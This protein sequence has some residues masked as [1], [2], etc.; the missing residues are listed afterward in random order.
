MPVI[1]VSG[2]KVKV[3]DNFLSMSPD[4]QEAT[5]NE[6]AASFGS[7]KAPE[8]APGGLGD[9]AMS[10]ITD[11]LPGSLAGGAA[12]MMGGNETLRG[13]QQGQKE[14][15]AASYQR[16]ADVAPSIAEGWRQGGLGGA[17]EAGAYGVAEN[18]GTALPGIA[19]SLLRNPVAKLAATGINSAL[20]ANDVLEER[21]KADPKA[22]LSTVD[23]GNV[24][25]QTAL[26][27]ASPASKATGFLKKRLL[28]AAQEAGQEVAQEGLTMGGNAVQGGSYT[29]QEV[30]DR[31]VEAAGV[32]FGTTGAT[33]STIDASRVAGAG[34]VK[35]GQ[36]VKD[37]RV[38]RELDANPE[39]VAS[40]QRLL[41]ATE[42]QRKGAV[43]PEAAQGP[44]GE[45]RAVK[46]VLDDL[47]SKVRT[48]LD[49]AK[50]TGAITA[51][52]YNRLIA[53]E[54]NPRAQAAKHNRFLTEGGLQKIAQIPGFSDTEVSAFKE[55]LVDLDSASRNGLY[56]HR[57]GPFEAAGSAIGNI[58]GWKA[59]MGVGALL[60]S[61]AGGMGALP[62]AAI[63]A[64]VGAVTG[65]VGG[66]VFSNAG[67]RLDNATGLSTPKPIRR[68][69]SRA[70]SLE[71]LGET[72]EPSG[73]ALEDVDQAMAKEF[74]EIH[75]V[76]ADSFTKMK[77]VVDARTRRA[78]AEAKQR[79]AE[80]RD[81]QAK[82]KAEQQVQEN[83]ALLQKI[84]DALGIDG[85]ARSG[86]WHIEAAK[87][88]R[89]NFP[90][91][92]LTTVDFQE[93]LGT[94]VKRGL[95]SEKAAELALTVP[96]FKVGA[97]DRDGTY[98][99][100]IN[101]TLAAAAKRQGL[102]WG[103]DD[104]L[105]YVQ[106]G[107][108]GAPTGP[109]EGRLGSGGQTAFGETRGAPRG[110]K[111][112]QRS[113]QKKLLKKAQAAQ[114]P[115]DPV[116]ITQGKAHAL[117]DS[118][119]SGAQN[120]LAEELINLESTRTKAGRLRIAQGILAAH[121]ELS[122]EAQGR[123]MLLAKTGGR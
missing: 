22:E 118:L 71:R 122:P 61:T 79:T 35:A 45:S 3:A 75:G 1:K 54:D 51:E 26:D 81:D 31:L 120:G 107:A 123:V 7:E 15:A 4:E 88:N 5:V 110:S 96:G 78:L 12:A 34:V 16:P 23:W 56:K 30:G 21:R 108:S 17:L 28:Q 44:D 59:G 68:A 100:V 69:R 105:S 90:Q 117:L 70:A 119:L 40:E 2:R 57:T 38:A 37:N 106:E 112:P 33:T 47:T 73:K 36:A 114:E 77:A 89:E 55:A 49:H 103:S 95:M 97:K 19:S 91:L 111:G 101:A 60:G 13:Y 74:G 64:G 121:P 66:E 104:I 24:A 98:M 115:Q 84:A 32:G 113:N 42:A 83:E 82:A 93:G 20:V 116:S 41:L 67:K 39:R 11:R 102:P 53:V 25:G 94:A 50:V 87:A 14:E 63:G 27:M 65:K 92:K 6:I 29:G 58:A 72:Y 9:A 76:Q 99:A 18:I 52:E 10:S 8:P 80:A 46:M 85:E 86:G 43:D 62:G 109:V 48:T